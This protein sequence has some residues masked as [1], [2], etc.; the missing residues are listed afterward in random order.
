MEKLNF[1]NKNVEKKE[2]P[3]FVYHSSSNPDIEELTPRRESIRDPQE[4]PVIF[5]TPDKALATTFLIEKASDRWVNI[6]YYGNILV[7]VICKEKE[8]FVKKDRGGTLYTLPSDNFDFDLN[9]GMK[10]K[11]WTSRISVKPVDKV[12]YESALNTM[13]ENG[14]QVYFV[15]KKT[16]KEINEAEDHGKNIIAQLTSENEHRLKNVKSLK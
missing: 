12:T 2:R 13:I 11:E 4:G 10:E 5:A 7:V 6:S 1:E 3:R 8:E 9:R 16:F 15:D 14:V